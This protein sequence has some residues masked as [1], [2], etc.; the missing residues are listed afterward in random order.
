[1]PTGQLELSI[2]QATWA[3]ASVNPLLQTEDLRQK[4]AAASSAAHAPS[5]LAGEQQAAAA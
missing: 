4:Q 5:G 1:M 3:V 2:E